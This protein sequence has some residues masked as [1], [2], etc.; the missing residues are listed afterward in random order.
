[1]EKRDAYSKISA[2]IAII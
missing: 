1:M 2:A